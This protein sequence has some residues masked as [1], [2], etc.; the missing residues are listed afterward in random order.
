M[1]S[2]Y[3]CMQLYYLEKIQIPNLTKKLLT[4]FHFHLVKNILQQ[5]ESSTIFLKKI[6][7]LIIIDFFRC[8]DYKVINKKIT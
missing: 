6:I 3:Y 8:S 7:I 2:V 1:E 4:Y 5:Y